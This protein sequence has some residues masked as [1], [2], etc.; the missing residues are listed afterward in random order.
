MS[1][2]AVLKVDSDQKF[3]S[4]IQLAALKQI[5]LAD[6]PK[7][8]LGVFLHYAQRTGLD[9]FARQL[10]MIARG[11][12]YTIQASIDGLRIV[13]Q[14]SGEYAGQAGPFWCGEDGVWTDVWLEATPPL[15]AKV[16]VM[17][18]GFAEPLWA[19]AKFE[20]YNANSPI[21][22]KMPDLMI[23][24]CAEALALRKAF[25]NDLSG[26]YTSEEMAQAESQTAPLRAELTIPEP[27]RFAASKGVI[28]AVPTLSPTPNPTDTPKPVN[29]AANT[30]KTG[31]D[32][33]EKSK[34]DLNASDP[35]IIQ[36]LQIAFSEIVSTD[37]MTKLRA[38]YT[39]CKNE[40]DIEF[41]NGEG[42][43]VTTL[44]AQFEIARQALQ[45]K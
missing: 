11:G 34:S 38:L 12:K 22:K 28:E 5:G 25:P 32:L 24:K 16:G 39:A 7:A 29:G 33:G 2:N 36:A 20:S 21:W 10:Y 45:T 13:A 41:P 9:P 15:A 17:R 42:S 1:E 31:A 37:D 19:V 43:G 35:N 23:A 44:R 18:K 30:L 40:L 27:A 4:E 8:E 6:A 3:W 14:R 26:I